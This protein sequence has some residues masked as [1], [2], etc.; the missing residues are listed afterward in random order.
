MTVIP[1]FVNYPPE[2][3]YPPTEKT[4]IPDLVAKEVGSSRLVYFACDIERTTWQSG[5]KDLSQLLQNAIRWASKTE[6]PVKISGKGLIETFAW[7]TQAG[8]RFM[9]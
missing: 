9:Y 5:N 2:L 7:E 1:P 6:A 3:V 4:D 8:L